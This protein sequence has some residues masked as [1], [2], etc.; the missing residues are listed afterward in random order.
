MLTPVRMTEEVRYIGV[1]VDCKY[2]LPARI[3]PYCAY[4]PH[5]MA[6]GT[7]CDTLLEDAG[8][9]RTGCEVAVGA[10]HMQALGSRDW[11]KSIR[12]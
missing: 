4:R 9:S 1:R 8:H 7:Q 6:L 11:H 12:V 10:S 5:T 3:L 2:S